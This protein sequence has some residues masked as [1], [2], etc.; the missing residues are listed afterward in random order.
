MLSVFLHQKISSRR[1]E[2]GGSFIHCHL[3]AWAQDSLSLV[4]RRLTVFA[5]MHMCHVHMNTHTCEIPIP[6]AYI[7]M[8]EKDNKKPYTYTYIHTH[9]HTSFMYIR[10]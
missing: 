8:G 7:P 1:L 2:I 5:D 10:G 3:P 4:G 6:G 9:T